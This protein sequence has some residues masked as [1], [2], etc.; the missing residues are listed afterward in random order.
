M[1]L[2]TASLK[3]QKSGGGS[4]I[5]GGTYRVTVESVAPRSKGQGVEL[6]RQYGSIRTKSGATEIQQ[7]DGSTFRLGNRKLFSGD[8]IEH[9]NP[10][11]AR[12]G[13]ARITQEAIA[14]GLMPAPTA[15]NPETD[16]PFDG[17]ESYAAAL[18]GREVL[19]TIRPKAY[20]SKTGEA[21][22]DNE[23]VGWALP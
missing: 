20:T 22:Q 1:G 9:P 12:V 8:W 10:E 15:E 7:A 3:D 11:A 16:L 14:A 17:W 2:L 5:P 18:T 21:K 4:S 19:L 6:A 23:V 13:H